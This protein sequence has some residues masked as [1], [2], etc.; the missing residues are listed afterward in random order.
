MFCR[1]CGHSL[2]PDTKVCPNCGRSLE[3]PGKSQ[4]WISVAIVVA[5]LLLVLVLVLIGILVAKM[6]RDDPDDVLPEAA[7]EQLLED[8]NQQQQ[9]WTDINGYVP[10]EDLEECLEEAY[11]TL[12]DTEIVT[13]C[14]KN[15]GNVYFECEDG[16]GY[17]YMPE[18]EDYAAG[19]EDLQ[20][21]TAQPYF[22][23]NL[24]KDPRRVCDHDAL[25]SVAQQISDGYERWSFFSEDSARDDNIDD[26]EV[27]IERMLSL[28]EYKLILWQ[29]HGGYS[30]KKGFMICTRIKATRDLKNKYEQ[31]FKNK[32]ITISLK[33][34][35]YFT[36]AFF[37]N[38]FP[39][40]AFDG[41]VIYIA[42]CLS[43]YTQDFAEIL[44]D[45]GAAAVYV[46]SESI[47]RK[48]NLD[49]VRAVGENLCWGNTITQ[50]L[51]NAKAEHGA[52]EDIGGGVDVYVYCMAQ[53]WAKDLTLLQLSHVIPMTDYKE[54][55]V[56]LLL[57]EVMPHVSEDVPYRGY[58]LYDIDLD[59]IPECIVDYGTSEENRSYR[60]YTADGTSYVHLGMVSSGYSVLYGEVNGGLTVMSAQDGIETC[61]NVDIENWLVWEETV[62]SRKV[63]QY[64]YERCQMQPLIMYDLMDFTGFDWE[65]NPGYDNRSALNA[66]EVIPETTPPDMPAP[67]DPVPDA[68]APDTT[69]EY[70]TAYNQLL[71][72]QM[73][74][75][76]GSDI[77]QYYT[78]YDMDL[79]GTPECLIEQGWGDD[80]R[81]CDVYTAQGSQAVYLGSFHT[82]YS[83]LY[84]EVSGGLTVMSGQDGTETCRK[85]YHEGGTISES[86]L[87]MAEVEQYWDELC[88]VRPLKMYQLNDT[89]GLSWYGNPNYDNWAA[90][91]A[92]RARVFP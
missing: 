64:W 62:S 72:E 21:V 25:D 17:V 56:N 18:L 34:T 42:T 31:L 76:G 1:K 37:E 80:Y 89:E 54:A 91:E 41:A 78:L 38:L 20:I 88:D 52:S 33:G 66:E 13:Y 15:T 55:Y 57:D 2:E 68:P 29:G 27:N 23:E 65:E 11:Q 24:Q 71:Q 67:E 30:N 69:P 77:S 3:D 43:G 73:P 14:E 44:L 75:M 53:D 84:G 36:E 8:L 58:T 10:E 46:N 47:Y 6:W 51:E 12:E 83:T 59:G 85:I 60:I 39:D 32:Y 49:M 87:Y 74:T 7:V 90:L 79:D 5:A 40:N 16:F 28:D 19:G 9:Q 81:T 22:T 61:R 92:D 50:A 63:D 35:L 45:K 48:Y 4:R 26:K 70:V 82:N 86:V